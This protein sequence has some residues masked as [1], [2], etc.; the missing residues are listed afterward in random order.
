MSEHDPS[1]GHGPDHATDQGHEHGPHGLGLESLEEQPKGRSRRWPWLVLALALAVAAALGAWL[2]TDL[3]RRRP[4]PPV[5]QAPTPQRRDYSTRIPSA[6]PAEP[7]AP[8]TTPADPPAPP[9]AQIPDGHD[10]VQADFVTDLARYAASHYHP[11]ATRDNDAKRALSTLTFKSLNMRYGTE[12]TGLKHEG[13]DLEA[14]REEIF[15]ALMHPIILRVVFDLYADEF[16]AALAREAHALKRDFATA[17]GYQS[18]PLSDAQAAELLRMTAGQ[19]RDMG[20]VFESF[21]RRPE[22]ADGVVRYFRAANEV[23]AA[24]AAYADAEASGAAASA[25]DAAAETIKQS[26]KERERLKEA[27]LAGLRTKG[28]GLS[29]GHILDIAT[30]I[31][32]RLQGHDG[33][34]HSIGA[35]ASLSRELADKLDASARQGLE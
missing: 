11:A 35:I 31:A 6:P 7:Q 13:Q 29:D 12:L 23:N 19:A 33:R 15:T 27:V 8:E 14:A 4:E 25:L 3:N 34:I 22:L 16:T 32:R 5:A 20:A 26:I 2:Y 9:V 18:R 1:M 24:Y 10:V 30:W 21:A 17:S 28:N